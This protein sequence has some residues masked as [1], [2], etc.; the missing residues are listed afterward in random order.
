METGNNKYRLLIENLPDAF[1]YNQIVLD[2]IGNRVDYIFLD[3]NPAFE[4]MMGMAKEQLIGKIITR[5]FPASRIIILN[6]S[7]C[8]AELLLNMR[9]FF[10][11]LEKFDSFE[12][13]D[14]YI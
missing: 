1:A 4:E 8:L 5:F 7:A 9:F 13:L 3:V 11:S 14:N 2:S 10:D 12:K 6:G